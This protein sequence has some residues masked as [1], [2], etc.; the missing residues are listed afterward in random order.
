[1]NSE[2]HH[3]QLL[4]SELDKLMPLAHEFFVFFEKLKHGERPFGQS[5]DVETLKTATAAALQSHP[6]FRD[7]RE[8]FFH[9]KQLILAPSFQALN[10]MKVATDRST[11]A[12]LDWLRKI[13][14][15][16]KASIR[17]VA[18]AHGLLTTE[19]HTLSNGVTFMP[20]KDLP[21]S[22]HAK[23]LQDQFRTLHLPAP[24]RHPPLAAT[25]EIR[26]A[27]GTSKPSRPRSNELERSIKAFTLVDKAA[28]VTGVTWI[29]FLDPDLT[30]AQ[31]GYTWMDP[32]FDDGPGQ[33]FP[34]QI[35]QDAMSLVEKYLRLKPELQKMCDV[36]IDR[37]N[38]G[39]R[40]Q[41]PG[42]KAIEG[43]ICLESLLGDADSQELTYKL[44]LRT[45]LLL[46]T[47]L[48]KRRQIKSAVGAF[49]SLRSKT[50]H[51]RLK[52]DPAHIACAA[53]GLD[54]CSRVLRKIVDLNEKPKPADWELTGGIA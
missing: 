16:R 42:N 13:Y 23:G 40:R 48:E 19:H 30:L 7:A 25:L 45:A 44:K 6:R 29:D 10:L 43:A 49:Y 3:D 50:V 4:L 12:A 8:L 27:K 15:T 31:Y 20:I 33:V 38:L 18:A 39:R 1:M 2:A 21:D 41:S 32:T 34:I 54:I 22:T 17:F 9:G 28:P 51:G 11:S 14:A 24:I 37:L 52:E 53:E 47:T 5:P 46:E 36:A 26:D 35:D